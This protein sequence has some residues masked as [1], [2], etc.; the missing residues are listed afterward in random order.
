MST[1][2]L[3]AHIVELHEQEGT[4]AIAGEGTRVTLAAHETLDLLN[5]LSQQRKTLLQATHVEST[6]NEPP[7]WL[8]KVAEETN[9]AP[10]ERDMPVDE[11]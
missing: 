1:R 8:S 7:E 9:V 10:E 2:D 6:T 5:W 4:L 3:G 11:P